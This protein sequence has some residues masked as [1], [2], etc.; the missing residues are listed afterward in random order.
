MHS[1]KTPSKDISYFD[2]SQNIHY[3]ELDLG[4]PDSA[5]MQYPGMKVLLVLA[6]TMT[7]KLLKPATIFKLK[8]NMKV[9]VGA[10]NWNIFEG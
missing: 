10:F 1:A 5:N 7:P 2:S 6:M 8:G 3:S 9:L 4:L